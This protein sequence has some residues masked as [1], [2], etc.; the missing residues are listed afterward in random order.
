MI[1][2]EVFRPCEII[3]VDSGSSDQSVA[4]A[5]GTFMKHRAS[6]SSYHVFRLHENVGY[7]RGNNIG[8]SKK[9]LKHGYTLFL[10]A[11]AAVNLSALKSM[12]RVMDSHSDINVV[13]CSH[14]DGNAKPQIDVGDFPSPLEAFC[15]AVFADKWAKN[16]SWYR[17][18]AYCGRESLAVDYVSGAAI[19]VRDTAFREVG[20][21]DENFFAFF[22][23]TDLCWRIQRHTYARAYYQHGG[24]IIHYGGA[25]WRAGSDARISNMWTSRRRFIRKHYGVIGVVVCFTLY[26]VRYIAQVIY[27]S[28]TGG[29]AELRTA[30]RN[31]KYSIFPRR[32]YVGR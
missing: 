4:V 19:M 16:F 1:Q 24:V 6:S 20:G 30:W 21:F 13:G 15:S 31:L 12:L 25:N 10:N 9:T 32:E 29:G 3:V 2:E 8:F 18:S 28:L 23:E 26:P 14:V 5:L 7:S 11:D 22:E 27:H 17:S